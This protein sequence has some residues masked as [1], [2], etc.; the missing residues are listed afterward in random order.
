[1]PVG[2]MPI[3]ILVKVG[4]W[5]G[6]IGILAAAYVKW[7][8]DIEDA[9][10]A[11]IKLQIAE[12]NLARMYQER[13]QTLKAL[14]QTEQLKNSFLAAAAEFRD[15]LDALDDPCLDAPV[16]R[17]LSLSILKATDGSSVQMPAGGT[18]DSSR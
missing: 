5:L 3:A 16:D 10:L 6:L 14:E 17:G 15:R 18:G 8:D 13:E 12:D 2:T 7:K 9:L 1:M 11:S 4:L